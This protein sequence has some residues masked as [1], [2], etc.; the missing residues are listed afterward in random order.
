[1]NFASNVKVD[2]QSMEP[3]Q[4]L[5]V[6]KHFRDYYIQILRM[7]IIL[8]FSS[9][10]DPVFNLQNS[11]QS[12]WIA[13]MTAQSWFFKFL[14]WFSRTRNFFIELGAEFV[15]YLNRHLCSHQR[16]ATSNKSRCRRKSDLKCNEL[17]FTGCFKA[18]SLCW[19][20]KV[21]IFN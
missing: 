8:D 10:F 21:I 1:M 15:Y 12:Q 16:I 20:P 3:F 18:I 14:T 4:I 19:C 7:A 2:H 9:F 6:T 11:D 5:M 13:L 17:W